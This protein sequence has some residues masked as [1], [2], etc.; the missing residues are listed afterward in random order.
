[1]R[2][3][4]LVELMVVVAIISLIVSLLLPA[5]SRAKDEAQKVSCRVA[6]RSYVVGFTDRGSLVFEIPQEAN[7][8]EC[9]KPRYDARAFMGS[10]DSP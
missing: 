6:I 5:F 8:H 3:V 9:H 1:M 7:C 4:S 2:G 10:I